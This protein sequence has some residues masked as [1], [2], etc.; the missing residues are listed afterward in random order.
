MRP[1]LPPIDD[2]FSAG[3]DG[4]ALEEFFH[5]ASYLLAIRE[6]VIQNTFLH[7]DPVLSSNP[8]YFHGDHPLS[9]QK[10]PSQQV[11]GLVG[12]NLNGPSRVLRTRTSDVPH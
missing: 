2:C 3:I 12:T 11:S 6:K 4:T 5:R 7:I 9:K 10:A 8:Y 1:S